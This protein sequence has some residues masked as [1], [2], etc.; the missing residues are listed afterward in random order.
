[1][2]KGERTR[3]TLV[4]A[5]SRLLRRQGYAATGLNQ[6]DDS[7]TPKG[8]LYFHFPGGKDELVAAA[9]GHAA[10]TW[11]AEV[12]ASLAG[13]TDLA[14]SLILVG[15]RL[16]KELELS[17]FTHGCPL[18]TVTLEAAATNPMLHAVVSQRYSVL[19]TEVTRRIVV[20][21]VPEP[22][23]RATALMVLSA[24]EGALLLARAHKDASIVRTVA[25]QLAALARTLTAKRTR[26]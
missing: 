10:D 18:A 22:Q 4:D 16:A 25:A 11:R 12:T 3:A 23:A 20:A 5:T 2:N 13:E 17:G 6:I 7:G 9:L 19:E 8:S 21:G 24:L 26:K 15:N 1:M 14:S